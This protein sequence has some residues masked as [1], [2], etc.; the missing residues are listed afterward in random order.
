M[1]A[2]PAPVVTSGMVDG[3]KLVTT[4]HARLAQGH[5]HYQLRP[6]QRACVHA[7]T[8]ARTHTHAQS[9]CRAPAHS[10]F[11]GPLSATSS[12]TVTHPPTSS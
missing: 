9:H 1:L 3:P 10:L 4:S 7:R 12:L 8:H 11:P 2:S 5:L 6:G